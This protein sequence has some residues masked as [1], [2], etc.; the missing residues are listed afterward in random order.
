MRFRIFDVTLFLEKREQGKKHPQQKMLNEVLSSQVHEHIFGLNGPRRLLAENLDYQQLELTTEDRED[1][2][3][4]GA[5]FQIFEEIVIFFFTFSFPRNWIDFQPRR[6]TNF[7]FISLILYVYIKRDI[8]RRGSV[9]VAPVAV[10]R[11]SLGVCAREFRK[12]DRL[13]VR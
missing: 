3:F 5:R 6:V 13:D 10:H 9:D 7:F 2:T 12:N 8:L 11:D 4:N 1:H